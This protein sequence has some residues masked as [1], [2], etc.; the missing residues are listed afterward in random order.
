MLTPNRRSG[1][2]LAR[3][4]GPEDT[5]R[6]DGSPPDGSPAGPPPLRRIRYRPSGGPSAQGSSSWVK[7]KS[8]GMPGGYC[9]GVLIA[10][11]LGE[12][13]TTGSWIWL[14]WLISWVH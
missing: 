1:T 6:A 11:W 12:I 2:A 7:R 8:G 5:G 13:G 10:Y 14:R 3:S 4:E 9:P